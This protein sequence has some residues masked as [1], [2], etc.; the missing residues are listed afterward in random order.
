MCSSAR[1][2]AVTAALVVSPACGGGGQRPPDRPDVPPTGPTSTTPPRR[3]VGLRF[4]P[5]A[6]TVTALCRR[7]GQPGGPPVYGGA[8][9]PVT[10]PSY[11]TFPPRVPIYCP[12]RL[13]TGAAAEQNLAKGRTAYQWEVYFPTGVSERRYGTPHAL[14]GGQ[15]APFPLRA[16]P[17]A[18]WPPAGARG[19]VAELR[20]PS[21]ITVA[22]RSSVGERQ[23]LALRFPGPGGLGGGPNGG[24]LG[25]ILNIAG[26]G[27]FISVHFDRLPDRSRIRLASAFAQ[28]PVPAT[29]PRSQGGKPRR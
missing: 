3:A 21:G 6:R 19:A 10:F 24:H 13:P 25:L 7:A 17:G 2:L 18:S 22:G 11:R 28:T 12:A 23:A 29:P 5:V 20:W 9:H 1:L 4:V 26:H 14:L 8:R 27:Y 15:Q 16:G